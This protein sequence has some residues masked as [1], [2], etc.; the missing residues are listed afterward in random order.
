MQDIY[1]RRSLSLNKWNK[2]L[3]DQY[4]IKCDQITK[5]NGIPNMTKKTPPMTGSGIVT[6]SAPNFPKMP[7]KMKKIPA[8]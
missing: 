1:H 3:F 8:T 7:N 6:N 5:N 4:V 2:L